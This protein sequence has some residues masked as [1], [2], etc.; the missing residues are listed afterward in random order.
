MQIIKA[1]LR[2]CKMFFCWHDFVKIA[3]I[4]DFIF[5]DSPKRRIKYW[6]ECSRC[7]LSL[8]LFARNDY[9]DK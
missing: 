9:I 8:R 2:F 5:I 3:E 6:Y 1:L 7:G 4:G